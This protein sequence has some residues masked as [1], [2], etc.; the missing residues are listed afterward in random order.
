MGIEWVNEFGLDGA[1][2]ACGTYMRVL[3]IDCR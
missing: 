1:V 2:N 3:R